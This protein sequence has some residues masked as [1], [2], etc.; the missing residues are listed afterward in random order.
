MSF[1]RRSEMTDVVIGSSI[2]FNN[3]RVVARGWQ[4]QARWCMTDYMLLS[5]DGN[6]SKNMIQL[7]RSLQ[8]YTSRARQRVQS[9]SQDDFIKCKKLQSSRS[10]Q[11]R[12]LFSE[13]KT[14]NTFF[15]WTYLK[16]FNAKCS[17]SAASVQK[18]L[19]QIFTLKQY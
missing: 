17:H 6:C 5:E 13:K 18:N 11:T 7:A 14:M 1:P 4:L 19:Y 9:G 12:K 16:M 10:F 15:L 8:G 2:Y 3:C